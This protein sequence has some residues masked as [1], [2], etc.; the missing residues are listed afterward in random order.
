MTIEILLT[1]GQVTVIDDVD[2][3]LAQFKWYAQ[4][5]TGALYAVRN[6]WI[7]EKR[8]SLKLHRVIMSRKLGRGLVLNER[9]DHIDGN[10]MNNIRSNLRIATVGQNAMNAKKRAHNKAGYKGVV[11]EGKKFRASIYADGKRR[12]L[13]TF[14]TA[15]EAHEAYKK[16]AVKYFGEFARFE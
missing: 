2:V 8:G 16:A 10:P 9:V 15:Q 14:P 7:N 13:G 11:P 5:I 3:D 6:E 12:H 1:R 4:G